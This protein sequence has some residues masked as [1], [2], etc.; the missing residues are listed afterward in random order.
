MKINWK[1]RI[2]NKAT[3][4]AILAAVIGGVYGVSNALGVELPKTQTEIMAL[5]AAVL[6]ALQLMGIIVDPTTSGVED[7][8]KAMTYT[9]PK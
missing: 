5:G 8:N 3:L 1:L 4:T 2:K 7:S 9:E 6:S